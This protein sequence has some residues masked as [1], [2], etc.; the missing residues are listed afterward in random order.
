[1]IITKNRKIGGTERPY[2]IAEI[3]SNH[4]GDMDLCRTMV[5]SAKTA[6]ADAVKFQSFSESSLI[7]EA[8]YKRRTNYGDTAADK[9]KHFGTLR[10]MVEKYQFTPKQH[11]EIAGYC[12]EIGI[13]FLSTPFSPGEV[14]LLQ[15][16]GVPLFKVA[17]MDVNHLEL[18]KVIGS[19]KKPVILSTGM[20]TLGEIETALNVLTNAGA[21]SVVLL[22]CV[23]MYPP[24]MELLNLNNLFLLKQAFGTDVGYSDHTIGTEA[25]LVAMALGATVIEKHYTTDKNLPGWDHLISADPKELAEIVNYSHLSLKERDQA[26]RKLAGYEKMLGS[27]Q[28][29][30]TPDEM[31]KRKIMR[32][33]IV[34]KRA[35]PKGHIL[36]WED[37]DYKRPGTG[38]RPD[39]A[40]Y[41]VG[42]S[43]KNA[44]EYDHEFSWSDVKDQVNG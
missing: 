28:R 41:I 31:N 13:E 25:P 12:K 42:R 36:S 22:H 23:S 39:E 6:G 5:L 19:T 21:P 29:T 9:H 18:L 20:S 3:G 43:L 11:F 33:G 4:N 27:Y 14:A 1:M 38:I 24:K 32:R 10:E 30:V 40:C 37:L 7:S 35:L 17:S 44:V 15:E 34:A 16:V 8:E 26:A 2:I